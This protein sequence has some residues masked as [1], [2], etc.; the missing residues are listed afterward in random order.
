MAEIRRPKSGASFLNRPI[1]VANVRRNEAIAYEGTARAM[2]DIA[3]SSFALASQFARKEAGIKAQRQAE[4]ER[5]ATEADI[6]AGE[7]FANTVPIRDEQGLLKFAELPQT[8]GVR[9]QEE[10]NKILENRYKALI[11]SDTRSQFN[12]FR[13]VAKNEAE[14]TA[15]SKAYVDESSELLSQI[16]GEEYVQTFLD[17]SYILSSEY[18]SGIR[19]DDDAKARNAAQFA[20]YN[21]YENE[22]RDIRSLSKAGQFDQANERFLILSND[23][24][25]RASD[26]GLTPIQTNSLISRAK[27]NTVDGILDSRTANIDSNSIAKIVRVLEG[28]AVTD[29]VSAL[30]PEIQ[31]IVDSLTVEEQNNLASNLRTVQG[32]QS[33][34]EEDA[35]T[36]QTL[37]NS[38]STIVPGDTSESAQKAVSEDMKQRFNVNTVEDILK[39][40]GNAISSGMGASHPVVQ[41]LGNK[42]VYPSQLV[43]TLDNLADGKIGMD[44][45]SEQNIF[46]LVNLWKSTSASGGRRLPKG[47]QKETIAFLETIDDY[48]SQFGDASIKRAIEINAKFQGTDDQARSIVNSKLKVEEQYQNQS[49]RSNIRTYLRNEFD[50]WNPEAYNNLEETYLD[51]LL[52]TDRSTAN[53]VI[54]RL[55]EMDYQQHRYMYVPAGGVREQRYSPSAYFPN[56]IDLENFE[57]IAQKFIGT[58]APSYTLGDNAF[59]FATPASG[60]TGA[61]YFVVD[62]NG[63][64]IFDSNGQYLVY[65]TNAAMAEAVLRHRK[66]VE[67]QKAEILRQRKANQ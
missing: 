54:E 56:E 31:G 10:A 65:S 59:L 30:V 17:R 27:V 23:I 11:E 1:G 12:E 14:F 63:R 39:Q 5:R 41:Y 26:L 44:E 64:A 51:L 49:I 32:T 15:L 58:N 18:I 33:K 8:L 19:I 20:F 21:N 57:N 4:E 66:R 28:G 47:L 6:K 42:N 45:V 24:A 34:I 40:Y 46:A 38:L 35:K 36:K 55:Y 9:G 43:K 60:S 29:E 62:E 50:D 48:T 37:I 2:Q 61:Q 52:R 13:R 22:L 7:L 16:G 25:D 53:D 67:D 3:N